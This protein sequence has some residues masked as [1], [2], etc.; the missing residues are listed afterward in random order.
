MLLQAKLVS[1]WLNV[2]FIHGVMDTDNTS[3]SGETIDYGP[4]AFMDFLTVKL[5]IV[6]LIHLE[7]THM[8]INQKLSLESLKIW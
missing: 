6:I 7:D 8:E 2:G 5:F 1:S 4:C 3:I